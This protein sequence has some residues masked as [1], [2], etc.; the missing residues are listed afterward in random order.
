MEAALSVDCPSNPREMENAQQEDQR[1]TL[2]SYWSQS[3]EKDAWL[4]KTVDGSP[5]QSILGIFYGR[6]RPNSEQF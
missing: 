6:A 2:F 1:C 3:P 5:F 4:M